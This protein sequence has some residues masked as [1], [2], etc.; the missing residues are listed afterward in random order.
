MKIPSRHQHK[1]SQEIVEVIRQCKNKLQQEFHIESLAIF[2]SVA[3]NT[4]NQRSDLDLLVYFS[5]LPSLLEL[6][7]IESYLY[8]KIRMRIDLVIAN[9]ADERFIRLISKDLI[10]I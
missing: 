4:T 3:K 10:L 6:A 2:G 8:R 1:N 7:K 5:K 9:D